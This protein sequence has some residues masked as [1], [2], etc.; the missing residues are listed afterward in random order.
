MKEGLTDPRHPVLGTEHAIVESNRCLYCYDAPCIK[1]CPTNINIPQFITR[2]G[3]GDVLGSAEAILES[4]ILG[5]S[6]STVCPVE[7]LCEGSCVYNRLED[8]P[9]KIGQLQQ[10]AMDYFYGANL[11][12]HVERLNK[13]P[14][15]KVSVAAV[16]SGPASLSFAAYIVLNGGRAV[17]YEKNLEPGGLN[18]YGVAPY[19]LTFA[20]SLAET[21]FIKDL[22]VTI[23]TG[24]KVGDDITGDNLL[25][26]HDAVFIGMGLGQD[27][28]PCLIPQATGISGSL[29]LIAQLK[30]DSLIALKDIRTAVVVGG[31]NTALDVV[32]ELALCGVPNI[33]LFYRRTEEVMSG[34][35]HELTQAKSLG[36]RLLVNHNPVKIHTSNGKVASITFATPE[37]EVNI[38]TDLLV[39]STGQEK[40]PLKRLFTKIELDAQGLIKVNEN[41][42]T[43][44]AKLYA[45]GDCVNGGK[46]VV[47][48]VAD[49]RQA[50]FHLLRSMNKDIYYG[51]FSN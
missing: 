12:E 46:E 37:G 47:D 41:F 32:Q 13:A 27:S 42:Q 21:Q 8:P 30:Q 28:F 23:K 6:C 35:K 15:Q 16:G 34:Y 19:K 26:D 24:I 14:Q 38:P 20:N 2:I 33:H 1:A 4:N 31:G 5:Y 51:R 10:Y 43:N 29:P 9:I 7:V 49:G 11:R 22:G 48:A 17:I 50:A 36:V 45:G 18:T 39:F 40:H 44:I 25:T 3:N